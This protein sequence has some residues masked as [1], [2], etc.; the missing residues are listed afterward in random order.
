MK[1]LLH[2]FD[3]FPRFSLSIIIGVVILLL[4]LMPDPPGRD[5]RVFMSAD[6]VV[7]FIMYGGMSVAIGMDIQRRDW[8]R[9]FGWIDVLMSSLASSLLGT[10]VEIMQSQMGLGRCFE[11]ADI[12]ANTLGAITFALVLSLIFEKNREVH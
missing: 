1:K 8:S 3:K 2:I 6:K 10:F 11:Y 7:H 12:V 9:R 4:T 5:I